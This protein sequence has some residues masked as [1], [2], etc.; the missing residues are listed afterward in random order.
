MLTLRIAAPAALT[1]DVLAVLS[2]DPA[3][4]SLSAVRGASLKPAGDVVVADV[5]REAANDVIDRLRGLGVHREGSLHIEP[6]RAWLSQRGLEADLRAPG[7]SADSV[8]WADVSDRTPAAAAMTAT[9]NDHLSG[10]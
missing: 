5:A 9:M 8:V 4:S 7:S 2:E 6:V 1:D 10:E 3:V